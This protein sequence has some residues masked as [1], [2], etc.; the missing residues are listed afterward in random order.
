MKTN[1]LNTMSF[2]TAV[3]DPA[4]GAPAPVAPAPAAVTPAPAAAP[5]PAKSGFFQGL[6]KASIAPAE[7]AAAAAPP[8]A[9][10]PPAKIQV[11][12]DDKTTVLAEFGTQAE[13]DAYVKANTKAPPPA[14]TITP[15]AGALDKP[16]L[17]RADITTREAA[18]DLYRK[19][20]TEAIR[21]HDKTKALEAAVA[22][23]KVDSEAKL[24]ALTEELKIARQ[25]PAFVEKTEAELEALFKENPYQANKY[26]EAQKAR[27]QTVR[28]AK[29]QAERAV[30]EKHEAVSKGAKQAMAN[31]DAMSKDPKSYPKFTEL[32]GSID[33]IYESLDANLKSHLD[34]NPEGPKIL[35]EMALGRIY[36][37][38]QA[39]GVEVK[40]DAA[41]QARLKAESDAAA[42]RAAGGAGSD[43]AKP[44]T[45]TQKQKDDDAWRANRQ[46]AR[47]GNPGTRIFRE[48]T[49]T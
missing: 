32:T 20:Q 34:S 2:D 47:Q 31:W 33:A 44:D 26:V 4:G 35:Y 16:F 15:A 24:A 23:S 30:R 49:K 5:A 28:S 13:A 8:A 45:R 43:P 14:A 19:S 22:Q 36:R 42:V 7:P 29:E 25:T 41:E 10:D 48:R 40:A 12:A 3:A 11:M 9:G 37:E 1:W 27:E 18:E 21:L 38:L 46:A 6:K 17:G 39:K